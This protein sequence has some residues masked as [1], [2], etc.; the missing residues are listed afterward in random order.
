VVAKKR[1]KENAPKRGF[2]STFFL[3][4][5]VAKKIVLHGFF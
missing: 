3:E 4:K 2:I 1:T 5:K